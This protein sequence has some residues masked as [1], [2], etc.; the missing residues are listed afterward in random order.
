MKVV[1]KRPAPV[2]KSQALVLPSGPKKIEADLSRYTI[3]VY[4]RPGV[5]K[6][7]LLSSFP[8]CLMFSCERVSK[9]IP[10]ADFNSENGGVKNW[11]IFRAGVELL[12]KDR[13]FKTVAI[14]TIDA[15]YN[16]CFNWVCEQRGIEHP[17]EEGWSKAW[18]AIQKEFQDQLMRIEATGRGVAFSSHSKE[19]EVQASS[20]AKFNRIQP[21]CAGAAYQIVKAR[22][23]FMLYAEHARTKE[24]KSIRILI[25]EGDE[26]IDAKHAGN[27]PAII[28]LRAQGGY[29]VL[30]DAFAGRIQGIAPSS[31]MSGRDTSKTANT[32]INK[33]KIKNT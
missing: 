12:E 18:K 1:L 23:D 32:L 22:T 4:A 5:G 25:T 2:Q 24:G 28:P 7:T 9:G 16:H 6:T 31:L 15:A 10:C 26:L 14:D 27:M 29:K 20:G 17:E 11:E 21:T 30:E 13:R 8:D 3:F 19:V 33:L